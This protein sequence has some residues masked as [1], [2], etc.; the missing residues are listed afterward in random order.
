MLKTLNWSKEPRCKPQPTICGGIYIWCTNK[1][2]CNKKRKDGQKITPLW[3][4]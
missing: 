1:E 4:A 2:V 3:A